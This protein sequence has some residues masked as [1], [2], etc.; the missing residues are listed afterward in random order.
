MRDS[1]ELRR[2]LVVG[3]SE[4]VRQLVGSTGF[5]RQDEIEVAVEL[6]DDRLTKGDASDYHFLFADVGGTTAG[7]ACYGAISCTLGSFD[8]YWIAVDR[9]FQRQGIGRKLLE[10][11]E[12][13]IASCD[14]RQIYIETSGRPQYAPTRAFYEQ[15]GYSVVAVLSDFY[16]RNDDKVILRKVLS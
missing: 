4:T 7:Y 5:F 2:T 14:G 6:V 8:L 13:L 11:T 9:R 3:D 12:R 15:C 10:E 16:D 1:L